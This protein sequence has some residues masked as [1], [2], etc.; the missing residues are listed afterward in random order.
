MQEAMQTLFFMKCL[1]YREDKAVE[2]ISRFEWLITYY[3]YKE[4]SLLSL[5]SSRF[6]I[7]FTYTEVKKKSTDKTITRGR[8]KSICLENFCNSKGIAQ[9]CI[10][11]KSQFL[12]LKVSKIFSNYRGLRLSQKWLLILGYGV[13]NEVTT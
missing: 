10:L 9:C 6:Y 5:Q 7:N 12:N 13:W 3:F 8:K 2:L 11:L 1:A 4:V